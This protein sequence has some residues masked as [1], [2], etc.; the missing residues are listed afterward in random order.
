[1]APRILRQTSRSHVK[2]LRYRAW[3]IKSGFFMVFFVFLYWRFTCTPVTLLKNLQLR[4]QLNIFE[5]TKAT[6]IYT[7]FEIIQLISVL[8]WQ[9]PKFSNHHVNLYK[10]YTPTW[11]YLLVWYSSGCMFI[12]PLFSSFT[13]TCIGYW[14]YVLWNVNIIKY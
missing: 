10:I 7:F 9:F 14:G 11:G 4:L 6:T 8:H 2:L 13:D 3:P 5:V 12:I 1:M